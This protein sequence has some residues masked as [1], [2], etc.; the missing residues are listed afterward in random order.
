MFIFSDLYTEKDATDRAQRRGVWPREPAGEVRADEASVQSENGRP[1]GAETQHRRRTREC[2]SL[3]NSLHLCIPYDRNLYW[4]N[5]KKFG[6]TCHTCYKLVTHVICLAVFFY[7]KFQN[8]W[9]YDFHLIP[10]TSPKHVILL[11]FYCNSVNT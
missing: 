7:C 3:Q 6:Q 11:W 5:A 9:F 8:T 2:R 10:I 1:P 4:L